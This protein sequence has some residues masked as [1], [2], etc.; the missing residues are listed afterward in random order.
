MQS[1]ALPGIAGCSQNGGAARGRFR[2]VRLE[3]TR[4]GRS[5]WQPSVCRAIQVEPNF[6]ELPHP[7]KYAFTLTR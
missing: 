1:K 7:H 3:V 2:E 6:A 4:D 5:V